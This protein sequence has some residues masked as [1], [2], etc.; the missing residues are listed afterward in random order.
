ML[1]FV[2]SP[3]LLVFAYLAGGL[4]SPV[5]A[6]PWARGDDQVFVS[7]GIELV[8]SEDQNGVLTPQES[9]TLYA[10]YGVGDRL[11]L[12]LDVNEGEETST[13]IVT[14]RYTLTESSAPNQFAVSLGFGQEERPG[15][16]ARLSILGAHIG[17]GGAGRL[18]PYWTAID[19]Q[20]RWRDIGNDSWKVDTTI[21]VKTNERWLFYG[22]VQADGSNSETTIRFQTSAVRTLNKR[23]KL[24][25]GVISGLENSEDLGITISLWSEF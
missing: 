2:Q 21:G 24:E 20:Y 8:W 15:R 9:A 19:A 5:S 25:A 1:R 13:R 23:L 7:T 10:E 22:Q 3:A 12:V 18:G 14:G 17:R 4:P 16:D 11:T 6:G